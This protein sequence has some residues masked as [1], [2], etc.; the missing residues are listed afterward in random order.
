MKFY[1]ASS[2][3]E[4]QVH[5]QFL[6]ENSPWSLENSWVCKNVCS[7]R[8]WLQEMKVRNP[9]HYRMLHANTAVTPLLFPFIYSLHFIAHGHKYLSCFI[10]SFV[11]PV[12]WYAFFWYVFRAHL[13]G[14][15]EKLLPYLVLKYLVLPRRWTD[16]CTESSD[17]YL[18]FRGY[19]FPGVVICNFPFQ[20]EHVS[21][22]CRRNFHCKRA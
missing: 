8:F 2:L 22:S 10:C 1:L 19:T 3:V 7:I 17:N 5:W 15:Q 16:K 9:N 13:G 4:L 14:I 20:T 12:I 21:N 6:T 18:I 11:F